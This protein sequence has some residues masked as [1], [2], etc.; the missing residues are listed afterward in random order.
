MVQTDF[1]APHA[2]LVEDA[3][4]AA[5]RAAGASDDPTRWER[6]EHGSANLV[7]LQDGVA[8]R[9]ARTPAVAEAS[10]RAQ[11]L[12]D[13]LPSLPFAVPRS[14]AAPVHVDGVVAIAQRRLAGHPHPHGSGDPRAVREV[15][16]ALRDAPLDGLE[17]HLA[18]ARSFMGAERW[19]EIMTERAVP[20]LDV[21][22][23]RTALRLAEDA[24]AVAADARSLVHGDLAGGNVLWQDGR[25]VGVLDW[26]LASLDDPAVDVAALGGWHGWDAVA[27]GAD[28]ATIERARLLA[29]THVLQALCW[30]I[31]QERPQ[32]EVARAVARANARLA[33]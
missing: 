28:S 31:V 24:A 29:A 33:A 22:V 15:L 21:G 27:L 13:A 16:D 9:V 20:M 19:P 32:A 17:E 14:L 8:V 18:P 12:V 10:L 2:R 1:L 26:D 5:M 4:G 3:A 11:R 6:V 7:L 30:T 23:R 25:V